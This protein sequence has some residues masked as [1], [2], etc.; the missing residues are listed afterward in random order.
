MDILRPDEITLLMDH[1][2]D[3]KYQTLIMLAVMSGARQGEIL[4]L[5]GLILIG[6]IHS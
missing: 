5:S 3:L 1:I 2:D 6:T 4:A